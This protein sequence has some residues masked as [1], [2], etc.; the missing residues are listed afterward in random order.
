[1]SNSA[2]AEAIYTIHLRDLP[3][4]AA[5]GPLPAEAKAAFIPQATGPARPITPFAPKNRTTG[6]P[7]GPRGR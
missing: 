1:M 4:D 5:E 6:L 2:A 7:P 3:A